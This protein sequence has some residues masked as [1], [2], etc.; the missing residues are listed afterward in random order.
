MPDMSAM[1][2]EGLGDAGGEDDEDG[3]DSGEEDMPALEGEE[4]KTEGQA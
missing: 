4:K 2:M 1:G 3:E